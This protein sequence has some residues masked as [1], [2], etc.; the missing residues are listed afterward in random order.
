VAWDEATG[1]FLAR[2]AE[3]FGAALEERRGAAARDWLGGFL[4]QPDGAALA[5]DEAP[6]APLLHAAP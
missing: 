1:R 2:F 6:S 3:G 5:A 4:G